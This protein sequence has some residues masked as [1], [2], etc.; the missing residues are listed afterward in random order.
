MV[1]AG[2]EIRSRNSR[3]SSS[4]KRPAKVSCTQCLL[5]DSLD[6]KPCTGGTVQVIRA[7]LA[8]IY[9]SSIRLKF[10]LWK[11]SRLEEAVTSSRIVRHSILL[12]SL[13]QTL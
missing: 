12:P 2:H 3:C 6:M 5:L 1:S 9:A 8:M 4:R 13:R 10:A 7:G 11:K